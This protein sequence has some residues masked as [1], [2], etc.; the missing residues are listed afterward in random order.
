MQKQPSGG[1]L[2]KR[3]SEN[4]QQIYRRA[5]MPK[6]DFNKV[7]F[8]ITLSHAITNHTFAWVFSCKFAAYSHHLILFYQQ[9]GMKS[10]SKTSADNL[11]LTR[12]PFLKPKG[13]FLHFFII[14]NL[15][16]MYQADVVFVPKAKGNTFSEKL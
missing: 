8:A 5:P 1:V 4:M 10:I 12:R 11:I 14:L 9:I 15:L 16:I 7:C 6:W 2:M 3:C 13:H